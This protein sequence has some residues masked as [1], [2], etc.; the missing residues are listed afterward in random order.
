M[1]EANTAGSQ[2]QAGSKVPPNGKGKAKPAET[3]DAGDSLFDQDFLDLIA[4]TEQDLLEVDD[5]RAELNARKAA[6][7]AKLVDKGLNKDAVKA[8]FK[9]FRTP[10]EKR[11]RFDLSYQV[12]RKALGCP[13]QDDLFVAAA[14]KTVDNH[15]AGK[16]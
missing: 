1:A 15:Q 16:H 7:M 2:Q 10:E 9:Y 6:M 11:E 3:K 12:V 5:S 4:K 14:Q 13:M 8:A